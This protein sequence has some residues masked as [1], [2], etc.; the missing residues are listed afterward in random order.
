M[1][2]LKFSLLLFFPH[3]FPLHSIFQF[4]LVY[5]LFIYIYIYIYRLTQTQS[6]SVLHFCFFPSILSVFQIFFSIVSLRGPRWFS[7]Y[8]DWL[9]DGLS[10]GRKPVRVEIFPT[11]PDRLWN[12]PSLLLGGTASFQGVKRPGCGN[13]HSPSSCAHVKERVGLL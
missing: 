3:S 1:V 6:Y 11:G 13:D 2:V 9:R 7:R 4:Q 10:E 12:P 8:R 5:Q